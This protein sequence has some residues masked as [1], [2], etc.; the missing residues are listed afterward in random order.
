MLGEPASDLGEEGE[1]SSLLRSVLL[2]TRCRSD[3]I[4]RFRLLW[5]LLGQWCFFKECG[6][7]LL[8]HVMHSLL[9]A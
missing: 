8:F 3:R 2:E 4:D 6:S 9:H 5:T 7:N 1:V